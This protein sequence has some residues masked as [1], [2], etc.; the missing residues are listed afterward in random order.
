MEQI[1]QLAKEKMVIL[2]SHR[3]ANVINA[4]SIIVLEN[5]NIVEHGTHE[6]LMK[7]NGTYASMMKT[8]LELETY[9]Q[10]EN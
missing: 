7:K 4:D 10:G 3:L 8:Q 5:G 1:Y 6:Y 9:G 2:I